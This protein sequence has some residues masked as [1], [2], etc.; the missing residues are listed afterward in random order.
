V[1]ANA[2]WVFGERLLRVG[3]AF[4]VGIWVARYL[5][6]E[7]YGLLNYASALVTSLAF[8]TTL[9][10]EP[11]AVRD[12]V[13]DPGRRDETLGTLLAMRLFG[14]AVLAVTATAAAHWLHPQNGLAAA[15]VLLISLAQMLAS[16]EAVDCWFQAN[17]T[18]RYAAAARAGAF[19]AAS[20]V[21]V[22]LVLAGA[23]LIAFAAAILL[24]ALLFVAALLAAYRASGVRASAWRATLARARELA[25][26]GWP[27][28]LSVLF[29]AGYLRIDQ[30]ML[31]QLAGFAEVGAYAAAARIVEVLCMAPAVVAASV[32]PAIIKSRESGGEGHRM[33]IQGLYDLLF[34]TA[35]PASLG[36]S[37][38]APATVQALFGESFSAAARPL[39]IL[40]WTL[41]WLFFTAARARWL[42]AENATKAAMTVEGMA[43]VANVLANLTLIPRYGAVGAAFAFLLAA[44]VAT[45]LAAPFSPALRLSLLMFLRAAGAPARLFRP[46]R[47]GER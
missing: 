6:V 43:C 32:F 20:A 41:P 37:I 44:P 13:R 7:Q 21:R 15:L 17:V 1:A 45:L 34:W 33:R 40:A 5:G 12:I 4:A 19:L 22:A 47:H 9:G 8:M 29:A 25:S 42:L 28:A 38:F 2:A 23:P 10:V 46:F 11:L 30:V 18:S 36:L 26:E 27:L 24:E 14:G 35:L 16:F 3:V 31:G 39:T